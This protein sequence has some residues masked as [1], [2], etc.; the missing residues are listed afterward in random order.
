MI[1]PSDLSYFIEVAKT[2]NMSRAAERIGISQPSLSQAI[3]RIEDNLGV[4]VLLRSK[5]G[6]VLTKAGEKLLKHS[7]GLS[8]MWDQIKSEV[9]SST[10]EVSGSISI[11]C[12]PSVGFYSL[13]KFLPSII[14]KNKNLEI[15][16]HHDLS[17]NICERVISHEMDIG[18]V[19]NPIPHP[20][21]IIHK[22]CDDEVTLWKSAKNK[23]EDI[24]ICD[25]DLIQ[26]QD[27]QKKISK[28][29][30]YKRVITSGSLENI[31]NLTL[32]GAGIGIL[33]TRVANKVS[34]NKLKSLSDAPVFKD[35][36]CVVYRVENKGVV[37][38][39]HIVS[40]IKKALG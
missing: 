16:L 10:H 36:L 39:S 24:L 40:E 26:T 33:P 6:V 11:G 23:N 20:D 38:I 18:I 1:S 8:N 22:L 21:L 30:D 28:K 15:T 31:A 34:G 3:K 13:D 2:K 4:D 25:P 29:F 14:E 9:L 37:A 32:A 12:H 19:I 35:K 7:V 27:I 17:R 5:K